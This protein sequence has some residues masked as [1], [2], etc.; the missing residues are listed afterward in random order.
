MTYRAIGAA[1]SGGLVDPAAIEAEIERIQKLQL[2]EVRALSS[3][4]SS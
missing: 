1:A 2:E 4:S 3:G